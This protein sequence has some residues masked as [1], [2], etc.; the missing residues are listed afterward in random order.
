MSECAKSRLK[1]PRYPMPDFVAAA[2][3]ARGL[4]AAYRQRP[5]Y[6]QNDYLG[7]ITRAKRPETRDKRLGQM[8]AELED[9]GRYMKMDWR[10][11]RAPQ[12]RR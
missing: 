5:D 12:A 8:L 3:N 1:R 7:W 6:Q 2:L 9:G 10:P 4:R 11:R